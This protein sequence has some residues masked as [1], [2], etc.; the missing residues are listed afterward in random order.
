VGLSVVHR[1]KL[2]A[3]KDLPIALV[4]ID[5]RRF[6][7]ILTNRDS[8][9]ALRCAVGFAQRRGN[10]ESSHWRR[11]DSHAEGLR[12]LGIEYGQGAAF[13]AP[14]PLQRIVGGLQG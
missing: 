9:S 6:S 10:R 14:E 3:V 12:T 4:K 11:H 5:G 1:R 8:E 7:G 2:S 13:A